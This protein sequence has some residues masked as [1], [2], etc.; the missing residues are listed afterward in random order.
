M[1]GPVV[2]TTAARCMLGQLQH[3]LHYTRPH[4]NMTKTPLPPGNFNF[5]G[6]SLTLIHMILKLMVSLAKVQMTCRNQKITRRHAAML[7]RNLAYLDFRLR[8]VHPCF[9][10]FSAAPALRGAPD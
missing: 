9:W 3:K 7:V 6:L 2:A 10:R 4:A 5:D 1:R 8:H